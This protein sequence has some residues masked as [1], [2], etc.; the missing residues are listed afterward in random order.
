MTFVTQAGPEGLRTAFGTGDWGSVKAL[1]GF[2][3]IPDDKLQRLRS[4]VLDEDWGRRLFV[5]EK[6]L[7]VNVQLA[8]EQ[9]CLVRD[10]ERL[11]VSAGRLQTRYGAPVYLVFEPNRQPS[12]P[13]YLKFI[14]DETVVSGVLPSPPDFGKWPD[15][16]LESE[17]TVAHDHILNDH[18]ERVSFLSGTPTVSQKCAI[19]GAI[20]WALHR[21]L[22]VRQR[23]LQHNLYMVPVYLQSWENVSTAP[24]LVAP[25]QVQPDRLIVR[26]LLPPHGSYARA[27]AVAERVD[28]LPPWL[29][30]GWHR[31]PAEAEAVELDQE[32]E[33]LPVE[34]ALREEGGC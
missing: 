34:S 2:A 12:P 31:R 25:L 6:Y 30:D 7:A 1:H 33:G 3:F 32:V 13:W 24:D 28:R 10:G 29:L 22:H 11:V 4:L 23:Y 27:R 21:G 18:Q 17:V 16:R 14:G 9:G 19:A 8:V 5:L 20:Q 15:L 26:T